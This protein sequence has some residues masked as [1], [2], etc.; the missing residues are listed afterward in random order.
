[1]T[2]ANHP[3]LEEMP[4]PKYPK[5]TVLMCNVYLAQKVIGR[6]MKIEVGAVLFLP[7]PSAL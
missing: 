7:H 1:M 3:A 2:V 6:F 5:Q 4:R